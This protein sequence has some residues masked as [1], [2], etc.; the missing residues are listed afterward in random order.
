MTSTGQGPPA[1]LPA[2]PSPVCR[3]RLAHGRDPVNVF[4]QCR[5]ECWEIEAQGDLL[6]ASLLQITLS[7]VP[8]D[9]IFRADPGEFRF[10]T[11]CHFE[12]QP[13]KPYSHPRIECSW[14]NRQGF[15]PLEEGGSESGLGDVGEHLKICCEGVIKKSIFSVYRQG[16][17]KSLWARSLFQTFQVTGGFLKF[18]VMNKH[19]GK[20]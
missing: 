13:L 6:F 16:F 7:T 10:L 20:V 9:C 1:D 14:I 19:E 3:Q 15:P 12:D 11:L 18:H 2:A 4:C 5:I 17:L 8:S